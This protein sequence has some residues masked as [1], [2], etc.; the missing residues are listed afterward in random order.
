VVYGD[1]AD[2]D[3]LHYFV[4]LAPYWGSATS[5]ISKDGSQSLVT[6]MTAR[7][8]FWVSMMSGV[9]K[10]AINGAGPNVNK[11]LVKYLKENFADG[12][13]IGIIGDYF[14]ADMLAAIESGGFKGVWMTG[15]AREITAAQDTG[16]KKTLL[17]GIDLM[18]G[19]VSKAMESAQT[20]GR[21]MQEIAADVEYS[22]RT[23]GAMDAVLLAGDNTLK[24]FKA[25]DKVSGEPWTLFILLQY[26]GEWM[27]ITR[28]I[29]NTLNREAA[30]LRDGNLKKISPGKVKN[31]V[32]EGDWTYDLCSMV[33][34]DHAAYIAEGET[35][36]A[37]GQIIS[38]RVSNKTKGIIIEDMALVEDGGLRLLTNI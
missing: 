17:K 15:A 6:G 4:N 31:T 2:A 26:L 21:T 30:A 3:E 19:A 14:P 33:R 11:A 8:N 36:L 13:S 16:F 20:R 35:E 10:A 34:S 23:A 5:I 27:I 7:V 32:Q 38:I 24:F 18:K 37:P 1:V 25:P 22:C 12:A 28:N 29:E 9:D